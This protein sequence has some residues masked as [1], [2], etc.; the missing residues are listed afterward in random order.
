MASVPG[1]SGIARFQW[2]DGNADKNWRRHRVSQ[3]EAE[4][5][6]F[7][8]PILIT[9]DSGHS[10]TEARLFALG[11]TDAGRRLAVV[12]TI[13]GDAVRVISARPM[14]RQERRVYG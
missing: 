9:S 4:Q 5:M 1:F 10:R 11:R 13:R 3:S 6:F 2:D 14:S 8:K 7:N 12:F